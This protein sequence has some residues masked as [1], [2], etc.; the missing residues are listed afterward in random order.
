VKVQVK[1]NKVVAKARPALLPVPVASPIAAPVAQNATHE[2]IP[3]TE[4]EEKVIEKV[5][6]IT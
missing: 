4:E 5:D 3:V 2:V 6:E 1:K